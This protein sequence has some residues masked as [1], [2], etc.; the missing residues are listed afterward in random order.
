MYPCPHVSI[1]MPVRNEGQ[2]LR[3]S[4]EAV[5]SQEYPMACLDILVIDGMSTDETRIR[6]QPYPVKYPQVRMLTN[7]GRIV[8]TGLNIGLRE[9]RGDIFIRV[10]G[11]T[12]IAPDYV[13]QCVQALAATGAD[14]VGGRM[15]GVASTP[16]GEA[17][18]LATSSPFGV[19]NARFH[20]AETQ[21]AVDTVYMGAWPR[22]VFERLGGF[23]E[24]LV[25][26]QDDEFNYRLR[27]AGGTILL[28]PTI[29]SAYHV[30]STPRALWC[31][32]LQYGYWKVRVLQKHPRQ[33]SL[34]HGV[35]PLCVALLLLTLLWAPFVPAARLALAT[36]GTCY[37]L[38]NGSASLRSIAHSHGHRAGRAPGQPTPW[39]AWL[40]LPL[41][42]AILHLAYGTGFLWGLV[43]F[44][45][46]W[47]DRGC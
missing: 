41:A 35:P 26:N 43:R 37:L 25:R 9:A 10:D 27:A 6:L 34:R 33:M 39:R 5:V 2:F 28:I 44:V 19:G 8:S 21:E 20:Y 17:V 38:A 23:D 18:V 3:T 40:W 32:Y 11:H 45:R 7:P 24:E 46:R 47:R 1:L 13:T 42:F 14:N 22:T 4:L 29:Q 15:R 30:R 36:M 12:V 31:Q 16:F